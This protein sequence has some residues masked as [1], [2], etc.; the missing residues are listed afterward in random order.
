MGATTGSQRWAGGRILLAGTLIAILALAVAGRASALT[1][2]PINVGTPYASGPPAVAV[3]SAGTAYIA[4]ANTKDLAGAND[5]VQYCVLPAG[6]TACA[7]SGSLMPADSAQHVD[8][9]QVLV[10]GSTVVVLTDVY[11]TAAPNPRH[12]TPEQEWASTDGG[13]TFTGVDGGLSVAD[14]VINADTAPL[15]AVIVPGTNVLGYGWDTADG[16]P[17]FDAFPLTAPPECSQAS[18]PAGKYATLEPATNPDTLGNGGGQFA[19]EVGANPGVLA[20]FPTDF[21]N[22]PLG[23]PGTATAQFGTAYAYASGAESA[24]DNYNLSPG[25]PN[26]A[27]K[28]PLTQADCNVEYPAVGGGPS[29]FG[30]V[31]DNLAT[32]VTEY[33]RFDAATSRFDTAPVTIAKQD[34]QS[35]SVSQDGSGGIYVTY[36]GGSGGPISLAYSPNDATTWSSAG[37][38]A[39]AL[40]PDA[41][42]SETAPASAVGASGQGW[43]AWLDNGSVFAQ[44]FDA[45]DA[46]EP[47]QLSSAVTSNGKTVTLKVSCALGCDVTVT[48]TATV[49]KPKAKTVTVA[50]GTF[51]TIAA[52]FP[53]LLSV[54][55]TKAGKALLAAD[56]D[57]LKATVLLSEK[58]SGKPLLTSKVVEI[59]PK[60]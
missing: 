38:I 51:P 5:F 41:D 60:K 2:K 4:W 35:P 22:G 10:D 15:S 55:A 36:L 45:S 17:T 1:G 19:S 31:E 32:H 43:V 21:G 7:H 11:G 16:P 34:E 54:P 8:G 49:T 23:C 3:D 39:T 40:S 12:Y 29:G 6:A 27:W 33:H 58:T 14:G 50:S 18:C 47:A 57:H 26:S 44:Q 37:H 48:I 59:T 46:R 13:A 20:V 56:H 25:S 28:L 9:V 53:T 52:A 42:H 24:T 30:I